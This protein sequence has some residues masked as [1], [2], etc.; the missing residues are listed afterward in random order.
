MKKKLVI[1]MVANSHFDPVWL[2]GLSQGMDEAISTMRTACDLLDDLPELVLTRGE[3]WVY[4][5]VRRAD[6]ALFERV[7]VHVASRRL[8][9]ANGWWVQSDCNLPL[10][11]SLVKQG[12]I[13]HAFIQ[14]H[15]G[16]HPIVGYNVDSFGHTATLPDFLKAGGLEYYI[17]MRP[18]EEEMNLPHV[19]F[20]WESPSGE[21]ILSV[22]IGIYQSNPQHTVQANIEW[23]IERADRD[24]G[25][26]ICFFGLGD[27]GGG[28]SRAEVQWV[29]DHRVFSADVELRMSDPLAYFRCIEQAVAAGDFEPPVIKGELQ[30]HAVGCYSVVRDIK[31]KAREAEQLALQADGLRQVLGAVPWDDEERVQYDRAWKKLLFN[32]FHD[33][34]PGT[35]IPA[36]CEEALDEIGYAATGFRDLVNGRFR[37]FIA[38]QPADERQRIVIVNTGEA[39][40]DGLVEFEPWIGYYWWDKT[41]SDRICLVD[42]DGQ[43]VPVQFVQQ[44][45]G[46]R[47]FR[48]LFPV[49]ITGRSSKHLFIVRERD[50]ATVPSIVAAEANQLTREGLQVRLGN[51]GIE[52]LVLDGKDYLSASGLRLSVLTDT[53]DTWS[54]KVV[55]YEE[56]HVGDFEIEGDW[57]AFEQGP[58]RAGY[59]GQFRFGHSRATVKVSVNAV[60]G[61]VRL[62]LRVY[63]AE[64]HKILKLVASPGFAVTSRLDGCP[65]AFIERAL[66]GKEYPLQDLMSVGEQADGARLNIVSAS[67]FSGDVRT[68]GDMRATL[69]RS[70]YYA[71]HEPYEPEVTEDF[72]V[73]DQGEHCFEIL[74]LPQAKRDDAAVRALIGAQRDPL[75]I[76]ET[77]KGMPKFVKLGDVW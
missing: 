14:E 30:H 70:A 27:H 44:A 60:D 35:S 77:T 5:V 10:P 22:R 16:I 38:Q 72:K 48:L 3:A 17:F 54:H 68:D 49:K 75:L 31:V 32:Q 66:D 8:H 50:P 34:L 2:W 41:M 64:T 37:A 26:A 7:K 4:D 63:W 15:F 24:L 42:E 46:F 6:P 40:F 29:L 18:G 76:G 51:T 69:L 23:A 67:V 25:H 21:S 71:H 47:L 45:A 33:I 57:V 12:E 59:M 58:L 19:P 61:S 56:P 39:D 53:T 52:A 1:H 55:G 28:P 36:A 13:G 43:D 11:Q 65:G 74:L 9:V 62:S 20:R 73:T